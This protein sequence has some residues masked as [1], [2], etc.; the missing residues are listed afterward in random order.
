MK[1]ILKSLAVYFLYKTHK[2]SQWIIPFKFSSCITWLIVPSGSFANWGL[3]KFVVQQFLKERSWYLSYPRLKSKQIYN[4]IKIM[5]EHLYLI[6][7]QDWHFSYV[8]TSSVISH[9][10]TLVIQLIDTTQFLSNF[11]LMLLAWHTRFSHS[12]QMPSVRSRY[13]S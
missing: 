7:W 2:S 5:N 6:K 4:T 10:S 12:H 3:I 9:A 1:P 8:A 11:F 13:L